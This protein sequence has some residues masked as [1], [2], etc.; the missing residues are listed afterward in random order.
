MCEE[1]H[2]TLR[3]RIMKNSASFDNIKN[4][5]GSKDH[6]CKVYQDLTDIHEPASV[7]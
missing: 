3:D 1:L 7:I 6:N 5:I 2:S 4:Y